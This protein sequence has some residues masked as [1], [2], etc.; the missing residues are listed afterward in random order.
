MPLFFL[1]TIFWRD[2]ARTCFSP[3]FCSRVIVCLGLLCS[4]WTCAARADA[5]QDLRARIVAAEPVALTPGGEPEP[6]VRV[7]GKWTG[8]MWTGRV[9]N[10]SA[11][12]VSVAEV[13]LFEG[14]HGLDAGTP[15]YGESFQMLAQLAGTLGR[16]EDLGVYPDRTH[17]RI[18]EPEGYRAAAG[19]LT[20][21]SLG[22]RNL[23][24]GF[25][26]CRAFIGRI[27]F[28]ACR[29]RVFFDFED[30]VL[31]PGSA[32]EMETFVV[33]ESSSRADGLA[34][35]AERLARAHAPRLVTR[36]PTGWCSWYSFYE[37]V[38]AADVRENLAWAR[39]KMPEI[40]YVQIDD[41]YQA[42][43]GDWLAVG[44][45]FDGDVR[46]LLAEIRREGFEPALWVAPFIAEKDSAI[47]REHPDWFV[48]GAD[49]L[50]LDSSKVG[51]GGWRQGPWYVLDGTHPEVQRHLESLF[52]TLRQEWG[53][54]YFKLD[55]NYWGAIHGG[56]RHDPTKTR[57]EAYR[58][59]MEAI[60]RGAGDAFI[61]GCNA[62]MWP[63][64]GLV[65]GMRTSGD[66]NNTRGAILDC[67]RENLGRLWQNG[68]IWWNDP[69]CV[70]LCEN[71]QQRIRKNL[72]PR[73]DAPD[74][75]LF[76]LHVAS[77]HAIGG[78]VF[79]GDH[80]PQIAPDRVNVLRELLATSGRGMRFDD[81]QFTI[82]R[83]VLAD[84]QEEI[85]LFNWEN[86]RVERAASVPAGA[87]VTDLW[88]GASSRAESAEIRLTL[89]PLS[90]ALLRVRP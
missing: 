51:F 66:I 14:A 85:A 70:L 56:I 38:T 7:E 72:P 21:G 33:R 48:K 1:T 76:R 30:L 87:L 74:E 37:D 53:V 27:G 46:G 32:R 86:R 71:T 31:E 62:P 39:E 2:P 89:P 28:N 64:I 5:M 6:R 57:I 15:V 35:L 49:G 36:P 34:D 50:P 11:Q 25:A 83:R 68:R 82:G 60:R 4:W 16:P 65:D 58:A 47:L 17:Y 54:T 84:G 3:R 13:V 90:A 52:R 69:D 43:M 10:R 81:D 22:E 23:L 45:S 42:R 75:N 12:P 73:V 67:A 63:S 55:A 29:L 80:L 79:S 59:G 18:A 41:G 61:L 8:D 9:V 20:L 24:L 26:S 77:I 19:V 40:R 78:M 44:K 88:S